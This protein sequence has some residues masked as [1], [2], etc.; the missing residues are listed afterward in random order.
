MS[1]PISIREMRDEDCDALAE[2]CGSSLSLFQQY[3]RE[4]ESGTR[5]ILVAEVGGAIAGYVLIQW[6]AGHPVLHKEHTPEIADLAVRESCRRQGIGTALIDDAERR[7]AVVADRAGAAVGVSPECGPAQVFFARRGYLPD[8]RGLNYKGSFV[9]SG[10][11][12][13]VDRGLVLLLTRRL[14]RES[15]SSTTG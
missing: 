14:G 15:P 7:I 1:E 12:V 6:E 5:T 9:N 8:V 3:C 11:T 10:A 13:R 4:A 2:L